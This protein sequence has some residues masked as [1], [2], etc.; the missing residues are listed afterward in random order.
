MH[1]R[2]KGYTLLLLLVLTG[3]AGR[4]STTTITSK[5]RRFL[6][7][8]LKESKT[9]LQKS[10][11]GIT[12]K[13][14][15]FKADEENWTIKECLQHIALA[16]NNLWNI[17]DATLKKTPNPREKADIKVKDE[18]VVTL[19]A[20]RDKKLQA[21]ESFKPVKA[22]WKTTEETL[23]AFKDKRME[24]IKYAKTSTA[25]MRNHVLQMPIGNIDAYQMLLYISAHTKRH[26]LQIEEVKAN[27]AFPK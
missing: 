24:I 1:K 25:D 9:G 10:V 8:E 2:T 23:D 12:D 22:S 17:A 19:L 14:L 16:E 13:Q 3:L 20:T 6:I 4:Q 7:E 27:P 11:K 15:N 26:T 21:P 5:E 18:D